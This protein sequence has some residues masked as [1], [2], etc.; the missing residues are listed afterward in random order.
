MSSVFLHCHLLGPPSRLTASCVYRE[1]SLVANTFPLVLLNRGA[2]D[3]KKGNLRNNNTIDHQDFYAL[4]SFL[5]LSF[6]KFFF[7]CDQDSGYDF[8]RIY[9]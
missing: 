8:E 2:G 1:D 3:F 5:F 6:R 4:H 9:L 7:Y